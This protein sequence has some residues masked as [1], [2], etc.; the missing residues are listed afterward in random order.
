V[1]V[2]TPGRKARGFF[3]R[4]DKHSGPKLATENQ[5]ASLI[6]TSAMVARLQSYSMAETQLVNYRST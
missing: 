3:N 6:G 4:S 2:A 5:T 1:I